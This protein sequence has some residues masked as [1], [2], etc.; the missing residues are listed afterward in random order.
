MAQGRPSYSAKEIEVF[1]HE[2]CRAALR[3]ISK[4]G[5]A[6]LSFRGLAKAL[7]C[8]HTRVHRYYTNKEALIQAVKDYAFG[9][10]AEALESAVADIG[11]PTEK[12]RQAGRAYFNFAHQDPEAFRVLFSGIDPVK[13]LETVNERRAWNAISQ[14]ITAAVADGDLEGDP[15]TLTYVF[16][17][18]LHGITTLSLSGNIKQGTDISDVL[19]LILAGLRRGHGP[20]E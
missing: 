11:M 17:S 3:I 18:A 7:N 15:D 5:L 19:H 10:F 20:S 4:E 13:P 1:R 16:W 2:V 9:E 12:M 6:T 14:P 8:S